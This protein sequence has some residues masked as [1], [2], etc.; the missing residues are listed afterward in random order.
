MTVRAEL[1]LEH[2]DDV[3]SVP[4]EAIGRRDEDTWVWTSTFRGWRKQPVELGI[5]NDTHVVILSGLEEGAEVAL[6]DP[7]RFSRG[8]ARDA[9][10]DAP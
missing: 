3:I 6:V 1:L 8:E 2:L 5:E 9:A 4:I 10:E 7:E